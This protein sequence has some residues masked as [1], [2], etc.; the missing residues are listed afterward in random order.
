MGTGWH[1]GQHQTARITKI[2]R[3][4][5]KNKKWQTTTEKSLS[6]CK[7]KK[8]A[9]QR[10]RKAVETSRVK[11]VL[12]GLIVAWP[13]EI[14][15]AFEMEYSTLT[16]NTRSKSKP[17]TITQE[18]ILSSGATDEMKMSSKL[19]GVM[20]NKITGELLKYKH[21]IR[22]PEHKRIWLNSS[23]NDIGWLAQRIPGRV[24]D[25]KIL[26]FMHRSDVSLE[27]MK[28]ITHGKFVCGYRENKAEKE[29]TR[30]TMGGNHVNYMEN[31][32]SCMG[33]NDS[34]DNI[35]LSISIV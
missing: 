9:H 29:R 1:M 4:F 30:L 23:G 15:E 12:E 35:S 8:V 22:R 11:K 7:K 33:D 18:W 24:K 26:L 27:R 25:T 28:D 10:V 32:G 34:M 3:D 20:L 14:I 19:V 6:Q 16:Q 13:Q 17:V 2:V 31:C 21:L 5:Y